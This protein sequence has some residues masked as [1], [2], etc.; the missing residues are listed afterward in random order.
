MRLHIK[1]STTL[2]DYV[3]GYEPEKGLHLE[4][5]DGMTVGELARHIGLPPE[6]IKIVMVN[7][8]HSEADD[9]MRDGD[10]VAFFPAVG[11][12]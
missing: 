9:A 7:G 11:G 4:V 3:H 2:R 12:G 10:R 8:R 1:L 5:P 6:E